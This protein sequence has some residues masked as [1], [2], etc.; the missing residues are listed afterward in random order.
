MAVS[1]LNPST[2]FNTIKKLD[3]YQKE[4]VVNPS[5]IP[6]FATPTTTPTQLNTSTNAETAI[7][8]GNGIWVSLSSNGILST[9]T[10]G[11]TWTWQNQN[12]LPSYQGTGTIINNSYGWYDLKYL[13]S[14]NYWLAMRHDGSIYKTT[15][16]ITWTLSDT[17]SGAHKR[18]G[19]VHNGTIWLAWV[20]DDSN[21]TSNNKTRTSTD[22]TTWTN[23]TLPTNW[24]GLFSVGV[25]GNRFCIVAVNSG[26]TQTFNSWSTDGITWNATSAGTTF[27]AATARIVGPMAS[28]GTLL[29]GGSTTGNGA[30]FS[31]TDGATW[32]A[33]TPQGTA[34]MSL[35]LCIYD[36]TRFVFLDN[37]QNRNT[38]YSTTG[39]GTLT[40]GSAYSSSQPNTID[41][42]IN[43][44]N[45][46][47]YPGLMATDGAGRIV[48]VE[49]GN[50]GKRL[51]STSNVT[52]VNWEY[53]FPYT[54]NNE[55]AGWAPSW[56]GFN[57]TDPKY[58]QNMGA[59]FATDGAGKLWYVN[60]YIHANQG[61][62][63]ST[64]N[65]VIYS[66]DNGVTWVRPAIPLNQFRIGT[67]VSGN[68]GSNKIR[69]IN[70]TL[71]ILAND[72]VWY[73]TDNGTTW[74]SSRPLANA[75]PQDIAYGNGI[76]ATITE[77]GAIYTSPT[78]ATWTSRS[79]N[80]TAWGTI[81]NGCSIAFNG[82]MFAVIG[83]FTSAIYTA[84]SYDG[85]TWDSSSGATPIIGSSPTPIP[86]N[87]IR[88]GGGDGKFVLAYKT[89][90]PATGEVI[91]IAVSTDGLQY[92]LSVIDA[93]NSV[94]G[95]IGFQNAMVQLWPVMCDYHPSIGWSVVFHRIPSASTNGALVLFTT[96][97][98]IKWSP[99]I[100]F[101]YDNSGGGVWGGPQPVHVGHN[102][103]GKILLNPISVK[104]S[105][106][107]PM[108]SVG[109]TNIMAE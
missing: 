66:T 60:C 109:T 104:I 47:A 63:Y 56:L 26:F 98:G 99:S 6:N 77:T 69:Y 2:S 53:T 72:T 11:V 38:Y 92:V 4:I 81:N 107:H 108:I 18:G 95:D 13:A 45:Y 89:G 82:K 102:Y 29:V 58:Q 14:G 67:N 91:A 94:A 12:N 9:S 105:R 65:Q 70:N 103:N 30:W 75:R 68:F 31:T 23:R 86:G 17:L 74:S 28:N 79:R 76:W 84:N 55:A 46:K 25:L 44:S 34:N 87:F 7:G 5:G 27:G 106:K 22:G 36:G 51:A 61:S 59:N 97:N 42:F 93:K 1:K 57:G 100:I 64:L 33:N 39:T 96:N 101:E 37:N 24:N 8:Y 71:V 40:T 73:S 48:V 43:W 15:D 80:G 20:S 32:T 21:G 16:L 78:L 49:A 52:N 90:T 88:F 3:A 85:I 10:D 35:D 62:Q 19:L 83:L 50:S 54:F 41:W